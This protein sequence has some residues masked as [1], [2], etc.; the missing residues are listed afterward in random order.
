[1]GLR[2]LKE[3]G[4]IESQSK[5]RYGSRKEM[6]QSGKSLSEMVFLDK[7]KQYRSGNKQIEDLQSYNKNRSDKRR[8][9]IATAQKK[10]VPVTIKL[11]RITFDIMLN[12]KDEKDYYEQIKKSDFYANVPWEDFKCPPYIKGLSE[13]QVKEIREGYLLLDVFAIDNEEHME[14]LLERLDDDLFGSLIGD[15]NYE[16]LIKNGNSKDRKLAKKYGEIREY[17]IYEIETTQEK[18]PHWF[19][20]YEKAIKETSRRYHGENDCYVAAATLI[21]FKRQQRVIAEISQLYVDIDY[22]NVDAYKHMKPMEVIEL[23]EKDLEEAGIPKFTN[24]EI[25]RGF[26]LKWKM[27]PIGYHRRGQWLELQE[28]I[29]EVLEKYGADYSVTTDAVRL[30]RLVGSKHSKTGKM[31]YGIKF[32]DDRYNFEKFFETV[33]PERWEQI[34]KSREKAKE[35]AN[36]KYQL[37]QGGKAEEKPNKGENV[38]LDNTITP[39]HIKQ[40]YKHIHYIRALEELVGYR[41]GMMTGHRE[42]SVFLYR[43]WWLCLTGNKLKALNKA[44]DLYFAMNIEGV[45]SWDEMVRLT[46]S[47]ETAWESWKKNASKGYNYKPKTLINLL[48]ITKEEQ[49]HVHYLRSKEVREDR[50]RENTRNKM[51]SIRREQGVRTAAEYNDE[52]KASK[53]HLLDMLRRHLERNPKA[54]RKDLAELLGVSGPRITQLKKEL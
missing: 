4:E 52:R 45:Y 21:E 24:A 13:Q 37:I 38:V 39:L 2:E 25:S 48:K 50:N 15:Y 49:Y 42:V 32:S 3:F 36:K 46:A 22:Y 11:D 31:I 47:A 43:Y 40:N 34:L 23:C 14:Y 26:N 5:S 41:E 51:E 18:M 33:L 28:R 20:T 8:V 10:E 44:K 17:T 27:S 30:S 53:E 29:Y 35:L 19:S 7:P 16:R 6:Y 12:A 9:Y 54:K 1:M